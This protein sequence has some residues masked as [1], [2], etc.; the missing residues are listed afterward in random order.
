MGE[1]IFASWP[2]DRLANNTVGPVGTVAG[3][4]AVEKRQISSHNGIR[5][6]P[7]VIGYGPA[8]Y[9]RSYTKYNI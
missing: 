1:V 3:V 5:N 6:F 2:L 4:E 7:G 9:G 8:L